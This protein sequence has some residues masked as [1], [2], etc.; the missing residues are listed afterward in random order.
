MQSPICVIF[1]SFWYFLGFHMS[2]HLYM[3]FL[4]NTLASFF[5]IH[6]TVIRLEEISH[7]QICINFSIHYK[8]SKNPDVTPGRSTCTLQTNLRFIT[9]LIPQGIVIFHFPT[10]SVMICNNFRILE[11]EYP[12]V[13]HPSLFLLI[14]WHSQT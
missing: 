7:R 13:H 10:V 4:I 11:L 5:L 9:S 12:S 6:K 14:L 3:S 8:K 2:S 1:V